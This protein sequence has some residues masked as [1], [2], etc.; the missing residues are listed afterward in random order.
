MF[1][2]ERMRRGY[3]WLRRRATGV[4]KELMRGELRAQLPNMHNNV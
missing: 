1:D 3:E 4:T 2:R